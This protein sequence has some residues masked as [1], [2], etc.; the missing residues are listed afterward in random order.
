M[1]NGLKFE[2]D[3]GHALDFR[4]NYVKECINIARCEKCENDVKYICKGCGEQLRITRDGG[5]NIIIPVHQCKGK[6]SPKY[7]PED[8]DSFR[9]LVYV[10][11]R[12]C[13]TVYTHEGT[14]VFLTSVFIHFVRF[15]TKHIAE[16]PISEIIHIEESKS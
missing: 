14:I 6:E 8:I 10:Q 1:N 11:Y 12:D 16:I 3:R 2:C 13:G 7:K 9:K 5:G 15:G 4:I